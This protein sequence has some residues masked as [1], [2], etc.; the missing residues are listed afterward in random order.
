MVG[1]W[2][3]GIGDPSVIGWLTV[4][5]YLMAAGLCFRVFRATRGGRSVR[6][7]GSTLVLVLPWPSHRRRLEAVPVETRMA[8][9]WLG[10]AVLLLLL[11]INKQLDLQTVFTEIGRIVAHHYDWYDQR[12]NVQVIF[13]ISVVL[14]GL[15]GLSR[16]RLLLGEGSSPE[17]RA[18]RPDVRTGGATAGP[19]RAVLAGTV[20]LLCFVSIRA[21]S[22]HHIDALLGVRLEYVKV[23]W[24]LELGGIAFIAIG[25]HLAGR[26][27]RARALGLPGGPS[28]PRSSGGHATPGPRKEGS[29][30]PRRSG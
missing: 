3:P 21:A 10:L 17:S 20:V 22:F 23:N 18:G 13:I 2:S 12:R 11:G 28:G 15:W 26:R 30:T 29:S 27:P 5:A 16:V 9:L 24:F 4:A 6:A 7:L 25:A 1:D 19:I 14:V 8:A